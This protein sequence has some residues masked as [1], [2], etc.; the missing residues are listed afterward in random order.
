M[1]NESRLKSIAVAIVGILSFFYILNPTFGI[2]EL[3]PDNFP[4]VGNLDEVTATAILISALSYFG[5]KTPEIFSKAK[6]KK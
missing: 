4:I 3:I 5:I 1:D 2:F 6:E